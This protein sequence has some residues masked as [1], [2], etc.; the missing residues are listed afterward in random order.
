MSTLSQKVI[1]VTGASRGIGAN[2][3]QK[4]AAAGAK[5]IINYAGGK[6]AAEQTVN[7]I[8]QQG[9]YFGRFTYIC[10]QGYGIPAIVFN[11]LNSLICFM[12]CAC[13]IDNYFGSFAG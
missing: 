10:S 2:I 8:K 3:A 4:L 5:V 7:T 13:I 6:E 1:L 11:S 9:G 12:L